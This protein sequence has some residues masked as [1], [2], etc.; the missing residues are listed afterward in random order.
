MVYDGDFQ[1]PLAAAEVTVAETG[2]KVQTTDEGNYAVSGLAPGTYT[3]VVSKEGYTRK[4][5]ADVVVPAGSMTDQD[6]Q[7][8]G[9]FT[10]ME[11]FVVQDLNMGGASEEGLLN[12]RMEAPAMMDSIGADLMSQAGAGD[13]ASAL[14]LVSG[15]TV[16]DGK[17]AVVR[18]LPDRYVNSQMN[19]VRLPT[20]DPDK[21]AVQLDQFPSA[22]LDNIQVS[23]TFTPDQQGD[24]SGGAV[25]VILKSVP[26]EPVLS[27]KIGGGVN[28]QVA[29]SD[30]FRTYDGGGVNYP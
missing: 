14:R 5:F 26:D 18:G 11:E 29:G 4:V 10:D 16:Q 28:S 3:L 8:S 20:A 23:K 9:E 24:A 27:F 12:L 21:R 13:A 2:Q 6:A 19:G 30:N 15:A 25:N 22:L 7:L 17:Y 1:A